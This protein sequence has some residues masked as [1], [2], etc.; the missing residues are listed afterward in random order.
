MRKLGI[1]CLMLLITLVACNTT[2]DTDDPA[3]DT[4]PDEAIEEPEDGGS[5][6]EETGE[7]SSNDDPL[8]TEVSYDTVIP[9]V[10]YVFSDDDEMMLIALMTKEEVLDNESALMISL[11]E[12]DQT[13]TNAFSQLDAVEISGGEATLKFTGPQP[14]VSLASTEHMILDHM[15]KQLGALYNIA[16]FNFVVDGESGIDYG[17]VGFIES[18]P[19]ESLDVTGV[20]QV[21][22]EALLEGLDGPIFR[23]MR[24][25]VTLQLATFKAAVEKTVNFKGPQGYR[26]VFEGIEIIDIQEDG[27]TVDVLIKGEVAE[28]EALFHAL[29]I[30][31][32][33]FDF[34]TVNVIDEVAMTKTMIALY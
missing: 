34:E 22:D 1:A 11:T 7:D 23:P 10:T 15:F 20:V 27:S 8:Y 26:N 25:M 16:T 24:D 6:D 13:T 3:T 14:F 31:A 28:E 18:L 19:V 4:R 12:S 5:M 17:Q 33:P 29:A 30:M 32:A 9:V 21:T 2:E